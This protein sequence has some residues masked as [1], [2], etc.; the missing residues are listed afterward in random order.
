MARV[1]GRFSEK[2]VSEWFA[3]MDFDRQQAFLASLGE[4]WSSCRGVNS[5]GC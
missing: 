2:A 4:G 5:L 1:N 3:V